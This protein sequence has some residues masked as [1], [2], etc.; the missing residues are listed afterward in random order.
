MRTSALIT[1]FAKLITL[2]R[3]QH[4][5]SS[6]PDIHYYLPGHIIHGKFNFNHTF[7]TY[8]YEC[9]KQKQLSSYKLEI[10]AQMGIKL[11]PL[12]SRKAYS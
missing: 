8:I 9:L 7:A 5:F 6:L 12:Y 3:I 2:N 11:M 10:C 4:A 1:T